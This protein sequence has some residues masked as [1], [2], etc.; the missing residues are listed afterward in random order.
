MWK[1]LL[2]AMFICGCGAEAPTCVPGTAGACNCNESIGLNAC[3][4]QGTGY[5]A[6]MCFSAWYCD[7]AY[8]FVC[9]CRD[10]LRHGTQRCSPDGST[11]RPCSC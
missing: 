6:C 8:T 10:G 7:P 3:N 5:G 11:L 4:A 9:V 1:F 2:I